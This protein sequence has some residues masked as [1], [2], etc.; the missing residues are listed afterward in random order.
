MLSYFKKPTPRALMAT[1]LQE[2][3]RSLLVALSAR[4]WADSQVAFNQ[5]RVAR[6]TA[7]IAAT[8]PTKSRPFPIS[9]AN[10]YPV[11]SI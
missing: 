3:E 5:A 11:A 9:S 10:S 4:E 7:S 8:E 2:A 1:E 6:L